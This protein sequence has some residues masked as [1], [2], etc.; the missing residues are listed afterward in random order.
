MDHGIA[1]EHWDTYDKVPRSEFNC[2]S[3][4]WHEAINE[5]FR[6]GIAVSFQRRNLHWG[7]FLRQ[8][9]GND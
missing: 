8:I 5:W 3:E 2:G 7:Y 6:T 1:I 9:L 4:P